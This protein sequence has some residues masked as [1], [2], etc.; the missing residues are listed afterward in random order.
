MALITISTEKQ[1]ANPIQSCETPYITLTPRHIAIKTIKIM[2]IDN[3]IFL[4]FDN[5]R[6]LAIINA[7][8]NYCLSYNHYSTKN[9]RTQPIE[10]CGKYKTYPSSSTKKSTEKAQ[11]NAMPKSF[12]LRFI[13]FHMGITV[14]CAGFLI[15]LFYLC[16]DCFCVFDHARSTLSLVAII[17]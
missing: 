14:K 1:I 5:F 7:P 12:Y 8:R 11:L 16:G 10:F 6:F 15:L 17:H 3:S 2:K 4:F 9:E 13:K